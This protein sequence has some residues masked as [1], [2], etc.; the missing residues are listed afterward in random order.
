MDF[1]FDIARDYD[2]LC[3][4]FVVIIALVTSNE[5]GLASG[6]NT[7]YTALQLIRSAHGRPKGEHMTEIIRIGKRKVV[8]LPKA[9]TESLNLN[10][11][12]ILECTV[13]DGKLIMEPRMLVPRDFDA[14]RKKK[15]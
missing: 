3:V 1:S 4:L 15:K 11:G 14:V 2:L 13:S 9:F 12:D 6:L 5:I 10:E 7:C 8:T